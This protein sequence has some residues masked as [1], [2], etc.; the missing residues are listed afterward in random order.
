LADFSTT[1]PHVK[2]LCLGGCVEQQFERFIQER[3]YLKNV[4]PRTVEWYRESFKWLDDPEPTQDILT[5][6]V[7]RMRKAGL[8]ATSCNNR[9]RAVNAYL[10]WRQSPLHLAKLKEPQT[11]MPV[12]TVDD[13]RR[14][15]S[16]KPVKWY[17]KRLKVLLLTL[18]DVGARIDEALSLTFGD[19]DFDN[20]LLTL[21]GK[22]SRDRKIP[23][24]LELRRHLWKWQQEHKH[25]LVFPTRDGEKW[26]HRNCHR[27]VRRLCVQL[28]IQAPERLLH[29]FRH[30]MATNYIRR[31]G[32]VAMLQRVLGHST[33]QMTMR[34]VHVQTEDLSKNHERVSLLG[35]AK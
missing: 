34:Y 10:K 21:H 3:T 17:D 20:L 30:T 35:G 14:V 19:V 15:M 18:A 11:V 12:Y 28:G 16:F 29:S 4:S 23:F 25:K 1:L 8:K 7:I 9:I 27:D 24:S 5:E 31:G 32:S 13:I 33:I 6:L 26:S 2:T 22:G